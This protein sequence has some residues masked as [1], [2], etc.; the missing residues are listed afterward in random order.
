MLKE[1][2]GP[3]KSEFFA[4]RLDNFLKGLQGS[5][6]EVKEVMFLCKNVG[7]VMNSFNHSPGFRTCCS[8]FP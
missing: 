6:Q 8:L 2:I 1:R 7:K 4:L 5:K 3:S